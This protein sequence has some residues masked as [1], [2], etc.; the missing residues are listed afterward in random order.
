VRFKRLGRVLDLRPDLFLGHARE[1]EREGHVVVHAHVRVERI[2]LEHHREISLARRRPGD[3]LAVEQQ[4]AAGDGFEPRDQ[5]QQRRLAA[6]RG[7]DEDDELALADFKV[8][9]LDDVDV[10]KALLDVLEFE[11]GHSQLLDCLWAGCRSAYTGRKRAAKCG[12]C[13]G[14][15]FAGPLAAPP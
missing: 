7:P 15:G 10:T 13:R 1:L 2:A 5:A 8:D 6:A 14:T 4:V 9:A 11:V 12:S 3:V